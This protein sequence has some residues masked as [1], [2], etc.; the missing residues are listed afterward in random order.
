[1]KA[2]NVNIKT[3]K[4]NEGGS[5]NAKQGGNIN[6]SNSA[7]TKPNVRSS[8]VTTQTKNHSNNNLI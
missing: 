5:S 8:S 2:P 3:I 6:A 1:M 4:V 7:A